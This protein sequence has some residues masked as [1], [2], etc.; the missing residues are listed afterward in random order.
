MNKLS[1]NE[2]LS[3]SQ[4]MGTSGF[5]GINLSQNI[6]EYVRSGLSARYRLLC[7]LMGSFRAGAGLNGL[8]SGA[9]STPPRSLAKSARVR[10]SPPE[11][12]GVQW[13]LADSGRLTRLNWTV[14]P[15]PKVFV[16][17][18]PVQL[19]LSLADSGGLCQ[20]LVNSSSV[21][22][23]PWEIISKTRFIRNLKLITNLSKSCE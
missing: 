18:S 10:Q 8:G 7:S 12:S 20:T 1:S 2:L 19:S 5:V 15:L 21:S 13:S 6:D 11:S 16:D 3:C 22:Q 23:I 9:L 14:L 17:Q 4:S